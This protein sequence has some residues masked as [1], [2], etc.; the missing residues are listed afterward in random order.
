MASLASK[1]PPD[2]PIL[3]HSKAMDNL[4][5]IR[6][7]M[8]RSAVFTGVPGWGAAAMGVVALGFAAVA[9]PQTDPAAWLRVWLIAAV[10]AISIA[11]GAISLKLKRAP[12][13]EG[14]MRK[15]G[16]G[17]VPPLAAGALLTGVLS[18]AG[19][20]QLIPGVWLLLY[21]VGVM[22]AGAYSVRVVPIMGA[23]FAAIGV[24]A[25]FTPAAWSNGWLAAGFGGLHIIFGTFIAR[26][27][28]G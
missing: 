26:R 13:S 23:C 6:D 10:V 7:T 16:F 28:G 20:W 4:A 1:P 19:Q 24:A 27:H 8:E 5:F 17:L 14:S 9:E 3:L 18:N 21:G 2:Q 25:F 22:T 12:S 15:F 11:V